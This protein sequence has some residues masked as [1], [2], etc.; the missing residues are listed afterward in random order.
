MQCSRQEYTLTALAFGL[1]AR[2][3]EGTGA[4]YRT[5]ANGAKGVE[6]ADSIAGDLH[7]FLNVP[8]DCGFFMA[9]TEHAH[10][11]PAVYT[12]GNAGYYPGSLD[13]PLPQNIRAENSS[14]F[15]GF[16]VYSTL[17]GLGRQRYIEIL[18]AQVDLARSI[19]EYIDKHAGYELLNGRTAGNEMQ[20]YS[21]IF[22]IVLFRAN[23]TI[24]NAKLAAAIN[25]RR[26]MYVSGTKWKGQSACRIAISNWQA[27]HEDLEVVRE[28]LDAVAV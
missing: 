5:P 25:T 17:V 19:A 22:M 7:K 15:R 12:N 10:V 26:K 14:R 3:L 16:A 2:L 1:F 8:Y 23:D 27:S 28:V 21:G 4:E 20:R 9:R 13:R 24:L 18:Q 6:Y 11:G